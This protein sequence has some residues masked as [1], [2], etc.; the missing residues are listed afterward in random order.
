MGQAVRHKDWEVALHSWAEDAIGKPFQWGKVDCAIITLQAYDVMH[1]TVYSKMYAGKYH[2]KKTAIKFSCDRM[3]LN[4]WMIAHCD[5][6]TPNKC[7]AGDFITVVNG[8]FA[9]G[10]VVL[11]KYSLSVI[12]DEGVC[13]L[14]T[15]DLLKLDCRGFR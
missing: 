6:I 9:L 14:S 12:P 4:R 13:L 5:E 2:D 10:H 7:A 11:G 15:D 8:P 3:D 1:N